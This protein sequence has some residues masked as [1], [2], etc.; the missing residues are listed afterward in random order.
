[1]ILLIHD[2]LY[3]IISSLS[4][5]GKPELISFP[6]IGRSVTKKVLLLKVAGSAPTILLLYTRSVPILTPAYVFEMV[7][8]TNQLLQV[9]H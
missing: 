3:A 2:L 9:L 6:Y 5:L 4:C 8:L 1:M 7:Y